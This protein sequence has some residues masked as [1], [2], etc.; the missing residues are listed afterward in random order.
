MNIVLGEWDNP[1]SQR[2]FGF[3]RR[4]RSKEVEGEMWKM[5]RGKADGP[6]EI[7][8]EILKEAGQ[9][10]LEWLTRLFNIIFRGNK[11]PEEWRVV[12]RRV[13]C[14]AAIFENQFG[15]MPGRSTTE[16]IHLVRRLEEQYRERK[17]NLHMV[18]IDLEKAY[19]KVPREVLWRCMEASGVLVAYIWGSALSPFLFALA[20]EVLARH[21][22]E[23]LP[24]C[25]L[26]ANDIVLIDETR[27]GV[28]A[29]LEVWKETLEFKGFKLSRSKT[30]YLECKR[31]D[32][33]HEEGVVVKIGTQVVPK[34]DS[35]KYL[36]RS[37][38]AMGRLTRMLPIVL[39]RGG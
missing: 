22:Q 16:A 5:S 38:K 27:E 8:I 34:K 19:D 7:P 2:D 9:A 39:E 33:M 18:F 14:S 35:F 29:R 32:G 17:K 6:D 3:C 23:E 15:F 10:G 36:G 24:L 11:M 13:R 28:N 25:M 31:S 20:L 12:E 26:F 4:I 37:F 30:K 21:I 1:G